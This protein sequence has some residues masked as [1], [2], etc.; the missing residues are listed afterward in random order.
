MVH[1]RPSL[2]IYVSYFRPELNNFTEPFIIYQ[3]SVSNL[4]MEYTFCNIDISTVKS[5]CLIRLRRTQFNVTSDTSYNLLLLISFY[6]SGS[7]TDIEEILDRDYVDAYLFFYYSLSHKGYCLIHVKLFIEGGGFLIGGKIYD[8]H[9][10]FHSLLIPKDIL[11]PFPAV[12]M[13]DYHTYNVEIVSKI[14]STNFTIVV[15]DFPRFVD[16]DDG[17]FII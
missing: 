1:L 5:K 10:K 15:I 7:V 12:I 16:D 13:L 8:N 4:T 14:T 9:H 6:S 3:T 17:K 2:N 11:I